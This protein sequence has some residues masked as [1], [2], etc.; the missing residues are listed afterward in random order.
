[1]ATTSSVTAEPPQQG[2]PPAVADG[3]A[4]PGR[5][6][7]ILVALAFLT[8]ALVFLGVWVV[9]PT[10]Y[11]FVRSFY[12]RSG[13][14]F[15]GFDNYVTLFTTDVLLTAI[16]KHFPSAVVVGADVVREQP[17]PGHV[18]HRRAASW[19]AISAWIWGSVRPRTG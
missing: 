2:A 9:Y 8:P 16:R 17:V 6:R 12:D 14:S 13:D 7:R 1:M 5:R 18:D 11:T 10:I 3:G 19:A 4:D 15:I